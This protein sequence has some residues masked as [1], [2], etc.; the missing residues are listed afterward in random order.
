MN[1]SNIYIYSILS[2]T[3]NDLDYN[4]L[5]LIKEY[6]KVHL[7]RRLLNND[8][9]IHLDNLV[10]KVGPYRVGVDGLQFNLRK[11]DSYEHY[12]KYFIMGL[13]I[14]IYLF[15]DFDWHR[16]K[17]ESYKCGSNSHTRRHFMSSFKIRYN[18]TATEIKWDV[19][20]K[21]LSDDTIKYY[22]RQL[23]NEEERV[24]LE[25]SQ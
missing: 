3:W 10:K 2:R 18:E 16:L 17:M 19:N 5:V 7:N 22:I 11:R 13:E 14:N 1:Q 6:L 15:E 21:D 23:M 25:N 9:N 20:I 4:V 12:S 24:L 8:F